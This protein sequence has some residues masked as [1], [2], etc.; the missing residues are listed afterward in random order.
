MFGRAVL[1]ELDLLQVRA[2]AQEARVD[3]DALAL[4]EGLVADLDDARLAELLTEYLT[5]SGFRV[6]H[7]SRGEE[8]SSRILDEMPA[9][10]VL[11]LMLPGLN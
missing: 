4:E 2:R 6:G 8:A 9:L 11:D 10:V 5:L 1:D 3:P 7:V